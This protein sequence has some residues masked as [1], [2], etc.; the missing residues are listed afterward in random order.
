MC[1]SLA[2]SPKLC[3]TRCIIH[4]EEVEEEE[5]VGK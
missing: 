1:K 5:D 3:M 2:A 4:E